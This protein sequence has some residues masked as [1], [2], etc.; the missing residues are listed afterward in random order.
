MAFL[1][2]DGTGIAG[3]TAYADI[4]FCDEYHADRGNDAW[5]AADAMKQAAIL[6][7]TD[8]VERLYSRRW[9]GCRGSEGQGLSWPRLYAYDHDGYLL[10][11]VPEALKRAVAEYALRALSATLIPDPSA[12]VG[13]V[14]SETKRVGPIEKTVEYRIRSSRIPRYPAADLLLRPLLSSSGGVMRA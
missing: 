8:H 9:I 10:E 14:A 2:E 7:A 5:T 3:A 11:G 13:E 12:T 4:A 1:V 6:K